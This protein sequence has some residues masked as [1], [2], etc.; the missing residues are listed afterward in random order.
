MA[1]A[2]QHALDYHGR[3]ARARLITT[4]WPSNVDAYETQYLAHTARYALHRPPNL[5]PLGGGVQLPPP[6]GEG[7]G[8]GEAL[9]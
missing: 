3:S 5:P 6:A 4:P 2:L 1:I 7:W 9:I 8:G